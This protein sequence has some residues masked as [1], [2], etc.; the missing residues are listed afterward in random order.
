MNSKDYAHY[1]ANK[2]KLKYD[3]SYVITYKRDLGLIKNKLMKNYSQEEI[4]A[5]IDVAVDEYSER[6]GSP[7]YPTPTIGMLCGWLCNEAVKVLIKKEAESKKA[8]DLIDATAD[9]IDAD[10]SDFMDL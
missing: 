1:F 3:K 7:K 9:Y 10:Y 2:F 6:W 8:N 5:I 4:L